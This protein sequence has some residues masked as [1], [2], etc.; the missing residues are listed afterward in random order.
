MSL[1][2]GTGA[3]AQESTVLNATYVAGRR[4]FAVEI[5][6]FL[7]EALR[8]HPEA[9]T[10]DVYNVLLDVVKRCQQEITQQHEG[11]KAP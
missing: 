9:T 5:R 8:R 2:A 1:I 3:T 11:G 10:T 4:A 6:T 7:Q